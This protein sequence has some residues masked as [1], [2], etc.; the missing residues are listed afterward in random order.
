MIAGWVSHSREAIIR[1]VVSGPGETINIDAV[2]D[3]GFDGSLSLPPALISRLN[4]PLQGSARTVLGD[5]GRIVFDFYEA[6]VIWDGLTRRVSVDE[7]DTDPLVGMG[8]LDGYELSIELVSQSAVAIE[9]L[10]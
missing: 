3:T 8:L 9:L 10:P 7:A 4:L 5:E 2:I 1:L 6:T